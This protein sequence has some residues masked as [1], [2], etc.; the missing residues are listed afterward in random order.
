VIAVFKSFR[1]AREGRGSVQVAAFAGRDQHSEEK[2]SSKCQQE[3]ASEVSA[4]IKASRLQSVQQPAGRSQCIEAGIALSIPA[5]T[6]AS[7]LSTD[8]NCVKQVVT[9]SASVEGAYS[10]QLVHFG[11]NT[12]FLSSSIFT[13]D[14]RY[15]L[16]QQLSKPTV[17]SSDKKSETRDNSFSK[18]RCMRKTLPAA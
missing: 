11:D 7:K 9:L 10:Q 14:E 2:F 6:A 5:V 16:E 1:V 4:C 8:N 18:D 17:S 15:F 3:D 13:P 12:R